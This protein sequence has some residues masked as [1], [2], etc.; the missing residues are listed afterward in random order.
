LF[1]QPID[2]T[3][4]VTSDGVRTPLTHQERTRQG[5]RDA[6]REPC[7]DPHSTSTDMLV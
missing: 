3:R 6:I 7:D 4:R 5:I 1:C 2:D